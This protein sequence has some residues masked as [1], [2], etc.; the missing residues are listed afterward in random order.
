MMIEVGY[1]FEGA[2]FPALKMEKG[3]ETRNAG[4]LYK[5]ENE[6]NQFSL[7][8]SRRNIALLTHFRTSHLE[9]CK[10]KLVSF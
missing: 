5:L 9:N 6:G 8:T 4:V 1:K 2:M 3:H 10:N 7:R